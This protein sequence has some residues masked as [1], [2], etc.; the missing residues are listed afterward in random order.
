[1]LEEVTVNA[2]KKIDQEEFNISIIELSGEEL[3]S[4][5]ASTIGDTLANELGVHNA[6][7]GP[8]VGLPVL[9]GLSGV[10]VQLSEDG[11][12]A[13]DASSISPDHATVIEPVLAKSIKVIKGPASVIHGNNA[14]GGVVEVISERIA[15][16]LEF[17][18]LSSVFEL[19]KEVN[20]IHSR[21]TYVGKVRAE[22]DRWVLQ[23]DGFRRLSDD[24]SI[25]ELAIEEEAVD[26][27]FGIKNTDNTFG[28]V[29]NTDSETENASLALSY[30]EDD[31]FI[32]FSSGFINSEYGM[33][34]GPHVEPPDSPGHSHSHPVGGAIQALAKVRIDLEQDR[35]I[36]KMGGNIDNSGV[37]DF[38][39]T[40]A[41][42]NFEHLEFE[43]GMDGNFIDGTLFLNDVF[44]IKA[45]LN[46]TLF[47][48]L[49]DQHGGKIGLQWVDREFSAKNQRSLGGGEN[50]IPATDQHS[51]GFFFY[52]RWPLSAGV[53]EFGG[54]YEQQ[55]VKQNELTSPLSDGTQFM[56][57]PISYENYIISTTFSFD[58]FNNHSFAVALNSAQR[59]P[60]IQELLS[61]GPHLAT[62]TYDFGLLVLPPYDAPDA[63]KLRGIDFHWNWISRLGV[64][65]TSIFYSKTHDFI[66]QEKTDRWFYDYSPTP[67]RFKPNC[68][69]RGTCIPLFNYTQKEVDFSGYE[70]QFEL[71]PI[72][73][74]GSEI[75]FDLFSD[76]VRGKLSG[77]NGLPRMPTAR[78]GFGLKFEK[79]GFYS[80]LRYSYVD[81][82]EHPGENELETDSYK[83][84]NAF[85]SFK[86][87]DNDF[88]HKDII[89]FIQMKNLLDEDIRKSTSF[90]RNF[91]PEPGR[92]ISIGLR[93]QF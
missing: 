80:E 7:Y 11:I 89:I 63:E 36:F 1:M 57:E 92:E 58:L 83:L 91:T 17:K 48:V 4:R 68:A 3:I 31:F 25:P 37:T 59:A 84:L 41:R 43:Q 2:E 10:R 18:P 19:R 39:L 82:Q 52:D 32:G 64:M 85:S 45:E 86:Y 34:P 54:R 65:N 78:R 46:H 74:Y 71:S 23:I 69:R 55:K 38:E 33:P 50:F 22:E 60:E 51:I 53:L 21:Q 35:H 76:H 13:W 47:N 81:R 8:G 49:N 6:S 70:W 90:L 15:K 88:T 72:Y 62:R 42:I 20:N 93:Y 27:I 12:G 26:Q 30:I 16:S 66:Y 67:G 9:R 24:M 40:I 28:T 79:G 44:E 77:G 61:V 14:I 87:E 29:L 5:Q 56:H 73:F 75:R